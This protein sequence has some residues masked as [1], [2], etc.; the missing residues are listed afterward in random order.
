MSEFENY[1]P[2]AWQVDGL[3]VKAPVHRPIKQRSVK[4]DKSWKVVLTTS[5][6]SIGMAVLNFSIP[7]GALVV[8]STR[9]ESAEGHRYARS[10][11]SEVP[12]GY[13]PRLVAALR[14]A[15]TLPDDNSSNDP[16]PLV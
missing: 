14:S 5:V 3:I 16:E 11:S 12:P 6:L 4:R 7:T 8:S 9:I 15:P 2:A 1:W 10:S 13:W